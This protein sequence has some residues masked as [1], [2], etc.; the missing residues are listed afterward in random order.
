[1]IAGV[2]AGSA[3][4]LF[5]VIGLAVFWRKKGKGPDISSQ[6]NKTKLNTKQL[7]AIKWM[8]KKSDI[9]RI[10]AYLEYYGY[11]TSAQHAR[12]RSENK[13]TEGTKDEIKTY[14][15]RIIAEITTMAHALHQA[16]RDGPVSADIEKRLLDTVHITAEERQV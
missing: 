11:N 12:N 4:I 14:N 5:G 6:N 10:V 16:D 2:I 13:N 8:D 7:Q 3:V 1:M 9:D 15:D